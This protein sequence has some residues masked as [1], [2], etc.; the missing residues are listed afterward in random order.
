MLVLASARPDRASF[1]VFLDW[2]RTRHSRVFF[3][4]SGGTDLLSRHWSAKVVDS[5]RFHEL[6]EL[7]LA[8][9]CRRR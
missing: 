3:L 1:G 6:E 8:I 7:L 9:D 2:A 4:G 5:Q